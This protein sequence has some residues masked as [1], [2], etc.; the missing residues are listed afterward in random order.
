M[1]GVFICYGIVKGIEIFRATCGSYGYDLWFHG[2]VSYVYIYIVVHSL[3]RRI[4]ITLQLLTYEY[5]V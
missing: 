3:F 2:Y 4:D 1:S 5:Y